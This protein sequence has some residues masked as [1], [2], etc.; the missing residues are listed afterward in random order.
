MKSPGSQHRYASSNFLRELNIEF[1]KRLARGLC[2]GRL[3]ICSAVAVMRL[4]WSGPIVT[5]MSIYTDHRKEARSV[6]EDRRAR[7][8]TMAEG[9]RLA[10]LEARG[11]MYDD[12]NLHA[13]CNSMSKSWCCVVLFCISTARCRRAIPNIPKAVCTPVL[14]Y[15]P[16]VNLVAATVE[17]AG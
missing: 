17:L 5:S 10:F 7:S 6:A 3:H 11:D 8:C 12:Q 4:M 2:Q 14:R 13:N 1:R 9:G 16:R 15:R